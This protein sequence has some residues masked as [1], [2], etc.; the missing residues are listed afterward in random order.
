[1]YSSLKLVKISCNIT[2]DIRFVFAKNSFISKSKPDF[3]YLT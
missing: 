2:V 1:M 3:K